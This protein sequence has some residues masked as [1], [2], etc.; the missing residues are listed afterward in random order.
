MKIQLRATLF[1]PYGYASRIAYR[2]TAISSF[3]RAE[4][5]TSVIGLTFP[6]RV[7]FLTVII[8]RLLPLLP[9]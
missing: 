9:T 4:L 5:V 1:P 7:S 2:H 6:P 8:L 3:L